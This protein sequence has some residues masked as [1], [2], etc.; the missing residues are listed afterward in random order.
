MK[1]YQMLVKQVLNDGEYKGPAREG[2]PGTYEVFGRVLKFDLREGFPL[3]TTKKVSFRNVALEL[4][5]FLKGSDK[6]DELV[7]A[8]VHIWDGNF[9]SYNQKVR[10]ALGIPPIPKDERARYLRDNEEFH[11]GNIYGPQWRK[12]N[13]KFDQISNLIRGLKLDPNSRYHIVTAWNPTDFIQNK[14]AAALPACHVMFQCRV[15][16]GEYLDLSIL[17]RSCDLMLGVPYNIASYALLVHILAKLTGYKP[18][19]LTWFGNSVHIYED[20]VE[21][22]REQIKRLPYELPTLTIDDDFSDLNLPITENFLKF[23]LEGY[24]HHPE[25]KFP[26]AVG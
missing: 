26:L 25:I 18:R 1:E 23:N 4:L 17:Q 6:L 13:G 7:K 2:I 11:M 15:S 24:K 22:A 10:R 20:H 19:E 14:L 12:W 21:G 3:L 16:K 5:W 9:F 8:G